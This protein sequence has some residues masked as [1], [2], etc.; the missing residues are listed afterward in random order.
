M[1]GKSAVKA[2]RMLHVM[3]FM[4]GVCA[5][6]AQSSGTG[7]VEAFTY[8]EVARSDVT[9]VQLSVSSRRP[10]FIPYDLDVAFGDVGC[11]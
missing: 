5:V 4:A 7:D 1:N 3:L 9:T 8:P 10:A 11:P 6:G 2:I